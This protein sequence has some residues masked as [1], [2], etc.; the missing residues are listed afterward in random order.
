[1]SHPTTVK[2]KG[3]RKLDGVKGKNKEKFHSYFLIP[4][5]V[6]QQVYGKLDEEQKSMVEQF[7]SK[8][9]Q[10]P[11]ACFL[12]P[13]P[14]RTKKEK[15]SA[16]E[17]PSKKK[18][19]VP[20]KKGKNEP[21]KPA[22]KKKKPLGTAAAAAAVQP[23]AIGKESKKGTK[24]KINIKPAPYKEVYDDDDDEN[25]FDSGSD[26]DESDQLVSSSDDELSSL[27]EDSD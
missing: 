1:M 18:K 2:S 11:S 10:E 17:L 9:A 12:E 20:K 3:K 23:A 25:V 4:N 5:G 21:A 14:K 16:E 24:I 8:V 26:T 15:K 6:F 13:K 19:N 22:P 27:S 7:N